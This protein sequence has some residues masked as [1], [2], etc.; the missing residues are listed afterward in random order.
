MD[1]KWLALLIPLGFVIFFPLFWMA[2]GV[3]ISLSGWHSL[4]AQYPQPRPFAGQY[5]TFRS[6]NVGISRYNHV[7]KVGAD[8]DGLW[9]AVIFLFRVGH[10]PLFFPWDELTTV[11]RG[12]LFF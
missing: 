5:A 4:A 3:L 7:L 10:P 9:L 6:G 1:D 2:I 8:S 12:G 11:Q